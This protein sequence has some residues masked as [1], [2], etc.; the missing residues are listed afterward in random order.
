MKIFLPLNYGYVRSFLE[1]ASLQPTNKSTLDG[2]AKNRPNPSRV[3]LLIF[4]ARYIK[5][6][7]MTHL[8][9]SISFFNRSTKRSLI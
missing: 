9:S 3:D 4:G 8:S 1:T 6:P 5:R 7:S 2:F